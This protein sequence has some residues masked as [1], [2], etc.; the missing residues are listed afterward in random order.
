MITGIR[1]LGIGLALANAIL[2]FC[3]P[4][5]RAAVDTLMG[6]PQGLDNPR[7]LNG[8]QELLVYFDPWLARVV[9]PLIYTFGFAA[10]GFLWRPPA[11]RAG[12]ASIGSMLLAM[13]LFGLEAVSAHGTVAGSAANPEQPA[14][15]LSA[16]GSG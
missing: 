16:A 10:L 13:V 6:R 9:L 4:A 5:L 2:W 3:V 7:I 1:I 8:V 14:V 15:N 12:S 11:K